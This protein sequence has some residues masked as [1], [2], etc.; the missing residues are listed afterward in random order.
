MKEGELEKSRATLEGIAI[1]YQ[2]LQNNLQKVYVNIAVIS[3]SNSSTLHLID[4]RP[5][6]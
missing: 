4:G 3:S 5:R 6:N 1:E 2:R